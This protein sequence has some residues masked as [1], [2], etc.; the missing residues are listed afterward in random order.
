MSG[1]ILKSGNNTLELKQVE[2]EWQLIL[3]E[4]QVGR[5]YLGGMFSYSLMFDNLQGQSGSRPTRYS[6]ANAI[7]HTRGLGGTPSDSLYI[8][9]MDYPH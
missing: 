3:N 4:E 8:S 5:I 1:Y 6:C 2:S 7:L 9:S